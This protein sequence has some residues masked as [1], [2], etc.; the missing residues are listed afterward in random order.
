V[1]SPVIANRMVYVAGSVQDD[2][3][4]YIFAFGLP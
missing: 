1:V 4:D 3:D 2:E